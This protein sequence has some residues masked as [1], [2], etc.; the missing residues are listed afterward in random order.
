MS[1]YLTIRA[2]CIWAFIAAFFML[3]VAGHFIDIRRHRIAWIWGAVAIALI[4]A[5][6]VGVSFG[7]TEAHP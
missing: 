5:G 1:W 6:C 2:L 3:I 7:W 4:I